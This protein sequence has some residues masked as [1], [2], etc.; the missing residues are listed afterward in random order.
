MPPVAMITSSPL[1]KCG[2]ERSASH[3]H[4][5]SAAAS[6]LRVLQYIN[7]PIIFLLVYVLL[8]NDVCAFATTSLPAKIRATWTDPLLVACFCSPVPV[9]SCSHF[10]FPRSF[11]QIIVSW[12]RGMI[13][14]VGG[15]AEWRIVV[16]GCATGQ[17]ETGDVV[18]VARESLGTAIHHIAFANWPFVR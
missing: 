10:Y 5:P 2:A 7:Q 6:T 11:Q 17:R 14:T 15:G 18:S 16:L 13:C 9:A 4:R 3:R 8:A 1:Q 12:W